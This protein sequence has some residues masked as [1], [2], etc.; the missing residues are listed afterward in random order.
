MISSIIFSKDR[1]LQLDL[2]LNS[3]YKNFPETLDDVR[4]IWTASSER[5]ELGYK[6]LQEEHPKII[7]KK[8]S[9]EF[10]HDFYQN[11]C[12][13]HYKYICL[14]TDD[15]IVY[16]K[17]NAQPVTLL[18]DFNFVCYSLRL[19][20]NISCRD[21]TD[22]NGQAIIIPEIIPTLYQ[23]NNATVW[24]RHSIPPGAYWSYP[25]SVDGHIFK[26]EILSYIAELIMYWSKIEKFAQNPNGLEAK[27]QRFNC[28]CGPNMIC[29]TSSSIINTPNNRV[30]NEFEN[31][32][33]DFYSYSQEH[34]NN[35]YLIG[36]RI[37]L[38]KIEFGEI[39]KAHK[40]L[41]ILNAI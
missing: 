3:I 32:H 9:S 30:Q 24:N 28:E 25:Y 18:D 16:R 13:A 17:V 8:Q 4:V 26:K 31:R 14:F 37:K 38:D 12:V 21:H 7:F 29:D 1:A 15:D 40:E 20:H 39:N 36:E 11:V 6:T 2:L 35:L 34:C 5:F 22:A 23:Y 33:G 27:M 19:G 41:N 10:F